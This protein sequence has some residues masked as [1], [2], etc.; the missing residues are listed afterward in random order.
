MSKEKKI[1]NPIDVRQQIT[2]SRASKICTRSS[3]YTYNCLSGIRMLSLRGC[4]ST[5]REW[6]LNTSNTSIGIR[7]CLKKIRSLK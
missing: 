3:S 4:V 5:Y 7:V 2:I 1:V 6:A